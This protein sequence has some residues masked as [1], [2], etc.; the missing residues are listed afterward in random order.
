MDL[1]STLKVHPVFHV[2]LRRGY[3]DTPEYRFKAPPLPE[4]IDGE[5]EYEVEAILAHRQEGN[6]REYLISWKGYTPDDDTWEPEHHLQN[7]P[8]LLKDYKSK[9]CAK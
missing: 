1:P 5:L 8:Q 9:H 7:C 2:S 6:S 3:K 4:V